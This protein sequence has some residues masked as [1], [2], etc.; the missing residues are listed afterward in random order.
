M[1]GQ[2]IG[3]N[4][5][6]ATNIGQFAGV[7]FA[8]PVNLV[9]SVLPTLVKG[10]KVTHGM[11]GIHIQDVTPDLA[12]QFG[13]SEA[14]GALVAQVNADSPAAKAGIKPGDVIMRYDGKEVEDPA[15]LRNM[16]AATAPDTEVKV[17]ILRNGKQETL[18]LR[19]GTLTPQMAT[20][21][22]PSEEGGALSKLGMSVQTLTPDLAK[23][24]GIRGAE[25]A[26]I[27]D[28]EEGGAASRAGLQPGDV[29][30]EAD[31]QKVANAGDL[32]EALDSAKDKDTALMLVKRKGASL[33]VVIRMK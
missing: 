3:M 30:V 16:V 22:A 26:V 25:G 33:F 32:Q 5:A 12:A 1:R 19:V 27:T 14:K 29:I 11:L 2:V 8:I 10:G 18:T 7:G 17:G 31:R 15:H 6:I 28:V 4:S 21:G 24:F 23:Q 20:E 9:K 13:L